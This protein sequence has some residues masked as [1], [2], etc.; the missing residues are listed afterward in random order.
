LS[1]TPEGLR[2]YRLTVGQ[3]E[4]MIAAA[5]FPE[6][7]S[8]ELLG[9]VLAEQM[10]K[11]TPHNFAVCGLADAL[12]ELVSPGWIVREEKS[13]VL[14]TYWRPEP[15]VAV[16]RRPLTHYRAK[17]PSKADLAFVVEVSESSYGVDRG[18]K[19]AGYAA[20][21]VPAYWIV[22]LEKRVIEVYSDP[23]GRSKAA[24][25][26]GAATFGPGE[27]VPVVV[28]GR[29]LGDIAVNGILP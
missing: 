18:V 9:G 8:V 2:P 24:R 28:E 3:F 1:A 7:A 27:S 12:R 22:S 25:Y 10:T 21:K 29:K 5:I 23:G 26:R 14:G 17:D 20:A 13:V 19:W 16:A 4:K 6:A 11:H 15:D